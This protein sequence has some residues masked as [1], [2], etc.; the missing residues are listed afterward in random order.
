[1]TLAV[2]RCYIQPILA[3][4]TIQD[5]DAEPTFTNGRGVYTLAAGTYFFVLPIG[6][7]ALADIHLTHDA[8]IAAVAT[9]ETCSHGKSEVADNS[10][11][12]GEWLDQDPSTAYVAMVGATTTQA[13]GV[14]T[15]VAGNAGGAEWSIE[16]FAPARGRLKLAVTTPG[17]VRVSFCGKD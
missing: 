8:A 15:I 14:V 12:A 1:M 11:V 3:D 10:I 7:S 2:N 9:V 5:A 13:S 4:G 17:E 6:G 16:G